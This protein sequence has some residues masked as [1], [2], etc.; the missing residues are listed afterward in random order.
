MQVWTQCYLCRHWGDLDSSLLQPEGGNTVGSGVNTA[1]GSVAALIANLLP[2]V[3]LG[4]TVGSQGV[5][6]GEGN[7]YQA[8][9]ED[10]MG[11]VYQRWPNCYESFGFPSRRMASRSR[12]PSPCGPALCRMSYVAAVLR[13]VHECSETPA[14]IKHPR[15]QPLCRLARITRAWPGYAMTLPSEGRQPS[16]G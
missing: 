2:Q 10:Q 5:Y 15:V 9:G 13:P 16:L 3:N 7:I 11:R 14:P 12:R 8:R 6:V 4:L 1:G